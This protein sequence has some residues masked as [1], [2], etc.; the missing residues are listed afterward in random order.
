MSSTSYPEWKEYEDLVFE[1]L[2]SENP[3][4]EFQKD[5]G[6]VGHI[7]SRSRQIDILAKGVVAGHELLVVVDCKH[8]ANSLDVNDVGQ[9]VT[10]LNDVAADVG[11]LVTET[12]FSSAAEILAKRSRIKL[13]IRGLE[14]LRSHPITLDLCDECDP[15]ED[16]YSGVI[17][18]AHP[19]TYDLSEQEVE[20]VGRCDWCNTIQMKC[21]VCGST[22]GIPDVLYGDLA[23]CLG[24]CGT[25][26]LVTHG[27]PGGIES[28]VVALGTQP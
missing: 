23:E 22:T 20:L 26:F 3:D 10:L 8:R 25:T 14:E 13:E 21:A 15:G 9:F 6:I 1:T 4:L 28:V 12:G 7:S 19:E 5:V 17:N 18:W 11:I 27:E 2:V 16:H 24:G